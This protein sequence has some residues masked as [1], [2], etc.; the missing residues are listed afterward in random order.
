MISSTLSAWRK[1]A[2]FTPNSFASSRSGGNFAPGSTAPVEMR[3]LIL[4]SIL[5]VMRVSAGVL[6]RVYPDA[7]AVDHILE[8]L[9]K[10]GM[11]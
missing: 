11:D 1:E 10:A 7:A 6:R 4:S 9:R 8:G 2:R 3:R 5:A